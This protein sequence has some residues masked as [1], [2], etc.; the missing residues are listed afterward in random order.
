MGI[1]GSIDGQFNRGAARRNDKSGRVCIRKINIQGT[2]GQT[3]L[4]KIASATKIR[5]QDGVPPSPM[6]EVRKMQLVADY[7]KICQ[8]MG[9]D[10]ITGEL[11]DSMP[12]EDSRETGKEFG[13]RVIQK[14]HM[15]VRGRRVSS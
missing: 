3:V 5:P 6:P 15:M 12:A 14:R 8:I 11:L 4:R 7:R 10:P 9:I 1:Q 13:G 2:I